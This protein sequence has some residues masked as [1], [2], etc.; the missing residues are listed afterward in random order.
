MKRQRTFRWALA[1]CVLVSPLAVFNLAV[2]LLGGSLV[3][4]LSPF[5]LEEKYAALKAY[6]AHRK[7]CL[8][9]SHGPWERLIE[10][11]ERRHGLP[12]GLLA[13]LIEVESG[14]R[15]HRISAAGAMGPGQLMP[16]TAADLRVTDPFSPEQS[17]EGS[18]R[19]LARQLRRFES[20][21]L[22]LAA[23]NA[24]PGN[25]KGTVPRNGE[26][27]FYVAKVLKEYESRRAQGSAG[28]P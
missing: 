3:F 11:A 7:G 1:G 21:P 4:P 9:R 28:E 10:K 19:Y 6:G 15:V 12:Q 16:A 24:G 20:V 25:V 2:A 5:F 13:A 17:I 23:Y 27:E 18:A 26:T 8:F 14:T 22:A